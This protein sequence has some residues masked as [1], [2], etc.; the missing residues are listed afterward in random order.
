LTVV[1]TPRDD[2]HHEV[3]Y[4]LRS[5]YVS[6]ISTMQETVSRYHPAW[7]AAHWL[8]SLLILISLL[9]GIFVIREIPN[10]A[11]QKAMIL[12]AHAIAGVVILLLLLSRLLM[13]AKTR[14]PPPADTDSRFL[15]GLRRV[16]HVGLYVVAL[17]MIS[18]GIGT[19]AAAGVVPNVFSGQGPLPESFW[20]YPPRQGHFFF[21]RLLLVLVAL[22]VAGAVYHQFIRKDGL[23]RRM[24]FGP[25]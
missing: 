3:R 25:R 13:R 9:G 20:D 24:W 6:G 17:A 1:R 5:K 7:V 11:P 19:L 14:K 18:T 8:S 21:S 2:Q 23:L 15:N 4:D 12:Q 10:A 16:V 22:H